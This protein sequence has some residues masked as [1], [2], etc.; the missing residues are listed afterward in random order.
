MKVN[1]RFLSFWIYYWLAKTGLIFFKYFFFIIIID[2]SA[3]Y[4]AG[5]RKLDVILEVNYNSL[6]GLTGEK[7][8]LLIYV[9]DYFIL[10]CFWIVCYFYLN[11][12]FFLGQKNYS[13]YW[14]RIFKGYFVTCM[15]TIRYC[16]IT[17]KTKNQRKT[18]PW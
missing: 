18:N 5:L 13:V 2:K 7:V 17:I 1:T 4:N 10:L 16:T 9:F 3:A 15:Q 11:S 14:Y 6:K 12:C 8:Y